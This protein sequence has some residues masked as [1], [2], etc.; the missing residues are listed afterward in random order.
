M[1]TLLSDHIASISELKKNPSKLIQDA[2][3][4]PVAILN[5]NTAAAYLVPVKTFEHL[6]DIVDDHELSILAAERLADKD[7][8]IEVNI[9][10]L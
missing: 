4:Q 8:F 9:N 5:H 2:E 1:Q 6:M 7:A 3:G 10:D